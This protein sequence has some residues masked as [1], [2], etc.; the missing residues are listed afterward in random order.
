MDLLQRLQD[1]FGSSITAQP[2]GD[3]A[4]VDGVMPQV[5][6][7]PRDEIA[8]LAL[9]AWCGREKVAFIPR[10]GG[11]KLHIGARPQSCD[12]IIS[13]ENLAG[14]LEHDEGN[15]TVTAQAGIG[16]AALN[17]VVGQGHQFLPLTATQ[18]GSRATLGGAV[19]CNQAGMTR[20]KYGTPRD[21]VVGLHAVL[22]DGRF[23]KAGSKVVKNVSGYDLNKVFTGSYGNLGLITE[24]T[25]RLQPHT[26]ATAVW[27]GR[28][29]S[30]PEAIAQARAIFE[31]PFEATALRITSDAAGLGV[32]T[33]FDGGEKS[34]LTQ[35]ERLPPLA[36]IAEP[37]GQAEN[38]RVGELQL[39]AVLPLQSA[40]TWAQ[41]AQER[42]A[43]QIDWDYGL[44]I[45]FA[46]YATI[47]ENATQLVTE[48]RDHAQSA[49]GFVV[50]ERAPTV[51]KTPD[52]V[53]GATTS[54]FPLMQGLKGAFDAAGVCAPGRF[55]G[56]L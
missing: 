11:T 45:V 21:L 43:S 52:F 12:L 3:A 27:Q 51:L 47:P 34:V 26:A 23:I 56:G 53:W 22:S 25:I 15:A 18:P 5:V 13:T 36:A 33:Q 7:A 55:V 31:G 8:A 35:M 29:V 9:V 20:L 1:E 40:G 28:F 4:V 6:A 17:D 39:C 14:V 38:G 30:W 37:P 46:A 54:A 44:G 19:A 32:L 48:L 41:Q 16:L 49:G 50:V 42:G 10:G 24:V 2:A